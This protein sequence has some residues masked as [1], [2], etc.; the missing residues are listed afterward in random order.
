MMTIHGDLTRVW[1]IIARERYGSMRYFA[2]SHDR[3]QGGIC[4]TLTSFWRV[5]ENL[6]N[7]DFYV[8]LNPSKGLGVKASSSVITHW[9]RILI[10][11]DPVATD[12]SPALAAGHTLGNILKNF[13]NIDWA[14]A[15]TV[16]D[17]GRGHQIWIEVES[18]PI[19]G[20]E[21]AQ[22]I[23]QV[24]SSLFHRINHS[25]GG[26]RIDPSCS[27]LSRVA[28]C[29]GTVNQKTG[30]RA[31]IMHRYS[32]WPLTPIPAA[33]I[34][35]AFPDEPPLSK[36]APMASLKIGDLLPHL[37]QRAANFLTEGVGSPGRHAAAYAAAASLRDLGVGEKD[38]T[39]MVVTGGRLCRPPMNEEESIRPV[40]NAYQK[41]KA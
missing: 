23:E 30:A 21:H 14:K 19:K 17:S 31:T 40:R 22:R 2:K 9:E 29:P 33:A 1:E 25:F 18:T 41:E 5:V 8:T 26:C 10:D 37:S 20:R 34:L 35:A 11:I 27:D 36:G 16:I 4:N 3:I 7:W 32:T 6:S 13:P 39:P 24:M 28:R 15:V 38:A 12:A